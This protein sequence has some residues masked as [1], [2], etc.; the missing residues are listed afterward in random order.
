MPDGYAVLARR[1]GATI[2]PTFLVMTPEGKY[3]FMIDEPIRP[4]VTDDFDADVR[5]CVER[6]IRVL[7]RYVRRYAEQWYVFRP[8]WPQDG[9]AVRDRQY[10]RRLRSLGRGAPRTG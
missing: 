6:S 4:R 9:V 10:L 7:E 1:F 3:K 8:V 5:D 2:V